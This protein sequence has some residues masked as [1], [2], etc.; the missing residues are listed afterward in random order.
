MNGGDLTEEMKFRAEVHVT[1]FKVCFLFLRL[2]VISKFLL[3]LYDFCYYIV[4]HQWQRMPCPTPGLV[5]FLHPL[6]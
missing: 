6:A 1:C 3:Q 4:L 2:S 5:D